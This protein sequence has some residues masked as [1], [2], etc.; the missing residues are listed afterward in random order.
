MRETRRSRLTVA[1][2]GQKRAQLAQF[3]PQAGPLREFREP[4]LGSEVAPGLRE[5][6]LGMEAVSPDPLLLNAVKTRAL[7]SH[8]GRGRLESSVL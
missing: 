7:M 1:P 3:G 8:W 5:V 6:P 4:G 2:R